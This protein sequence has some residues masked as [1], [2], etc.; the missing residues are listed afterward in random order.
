V[1]AVSRFFKTPKGLLIIV[2][3]MLTVMASPGEGIALVAPGLAGAVAVA[4]VIDGLILRRKRN[5]WE[6][7]SGAVLTGLF[8][9]MVLSPHEPWYVAVST[10]AFAVVSKYVVRTR[11]ANVFNPAALA[12]VVSFY[13]FHAAQSWWGALPEMTPAGLIVLFA[14][15]A[16]IADR[17]NKIPLV[18]AFLGSYY[19]LFTLTAFLGDPR[20]VAEIFRSPD[21]QAVLFFSFFFL[22]DPPTSPVKYPDQLVCGVIVA[23][24]SY[25]VF[26]VVGAAH[27]LLAGVLVGNV[28]EA[29]RRGFARKGD[30]PAIGN[31][32]AVAVGLLLAIAV[33]RGV[34]AQGTPGDPTWKLCRDANPD[35]SIAGCGALI[36]SGREKGSN[37]STAY[38]LRGVAYMALQDFDRAIQDFAQAIQIDPTN[39][40]AF[41]NRGAAFGARQEWDSA[42]RDFTQVVTLD[43]KSSH[44]F[45]DRGSM[46]L[47]TGQS[48]LAIRDFTDAIRLDPAFAD[49]LLNRGLTLA[50][51]ARCPQA[52]A[53][54]TRVIE[55]DPKASKAY[56]ERGVCY[57]AAGDDTRALDD[58]SAHLALEPRSFY[59]LERRAA[60]LF[61]T[62]Q[63]DRALDDYMQ[64]VLIMPNSARA[65]YG[66]GIVRLKKGDTRAGNDDVALAKALRPN[67][68]EEMAVRGLTP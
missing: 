37:L 61:R 43:P 60:L 53:D 65:L 30:A 19:L 2:L 21:L 6:F 18:L 58:F 17:V 39:T 24:A 10:S 49:A 32:R 59:G 1:S 11:A 48:D 66:R 51:S 35:I 7:P 16:F 31:Q 63:Y 29:W 55:L 64:A 22:T 46:Y 67:I 3:G 36:R 52:I 57:E 45:H 13:V 26:E 54:F 12:I 41:M 33:A 23:A 56:V 20:G 27:Y 62:A 5:A 14:T 34:S 25:A 40:E 4:A 28:W 68:A 9:A 42:I 15:G 44:A 8:V 47:L 38:S 50:G